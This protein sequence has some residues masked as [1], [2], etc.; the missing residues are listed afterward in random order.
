MRM[1]DN[2]KHD[3][4]IL[5]ISI[6]I[7]ILMFQLEISNYCPLIKYY[8][9]LLSIVLLVYFFIKRKFVTK[10]E[11]LFMLMSFGI[12][13]LFGCI[14]NLRSSINNSFFIMLVDA[15]GIF[16]IFFALFA[17]KNVFSNKECDNCIRLL[18]RILQAYVFIAA[19]SY[20]LAILLN[21]GWMF[22]QTRFGFKTYG[23]V[24]GYAGDGWLGY[25]L[26]ACYCLFTMSN[27][28]L[29]FPRVTKTICLL[30]TVLTIKGPALLFVALVVLY[31]YVIKKNKFDFRHII[32]TLIIGVSVGWW[33]IQRYL[34]TTGEA[35]NYLNT[36]GFEIALDYFPTGLG[37]ATFGSD[38]SRKFY[39]QAYYI[40][41]L[42]NVYGL[43][44]G[45]FT[46][47]ITDNY[48]GMLFGQTGFFGVIAIAF[49]YYTIFNKINKKP[50]VTDKTKYA[51][52]AMFFSFMAGSIGSAYLTS[53][54][55]VICFLIIGIYINPKWHNLNKS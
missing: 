27:S 10:K 53:H 37:F 52:L 17:T 50:N 54:I 46:S 3:I 26:E 45:G 5:F 1:T 25:Y 30:L 18:S 32:F 13:L 6:S 19:I 48:W 9:E 21:W 44:G 16:K 43:G 41:G 20:I 4:K 15:L 34:L 12:I 36:V 40:Y 7:L 47:Y 14:G 31:N 38:L 49:V 42:N 29:K 24:H 35:R 51:F 28:S 55:G 8:D 33:Y 2:S 11:D 23:F 39:S 22:K